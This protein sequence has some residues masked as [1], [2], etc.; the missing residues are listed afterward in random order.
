[1][2]TTKILFDELGLKHGDIRALQNLPMDRLI[3]ASDAIETRVPLS[4]AGMAANS[5]TVDGGVIPQ[6]P[7]DPAGPALPVR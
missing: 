7:W 1:V 3:A 2:R 5:P 4:E 6:H